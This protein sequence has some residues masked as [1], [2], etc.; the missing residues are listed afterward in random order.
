MKPHKQF[1]TTRAARGVASRMRREAARRM[2]RRLI[3]QLRHL[4]S[5]P[6]PPGQHRL[7]QQYPWRAP[8]M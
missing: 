2:T 8:R 4:A 6:V 1:A 3:K 7:A 5:E